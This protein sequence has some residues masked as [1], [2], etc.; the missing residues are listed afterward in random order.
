MVGERIHQVTM[1]LDAVAVLVAGPAVAR[2]VLVVGGDAVDEG[3][4]N[5]DRQVEASPVPGDDPRFVAL[6]AAPEAGEELLLGRAQLAARAALLDGVGLAVTVAHE[7]R[8][9][10]ADRDHPVLDRLA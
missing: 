2:L 8:R 1:R 9:E 3:A 5:Q 6:E 10:E 7:A 4:L